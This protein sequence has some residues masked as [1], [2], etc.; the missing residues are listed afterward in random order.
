LLYAPTKPDIYFPLATNPLQLEPTV[1]DVVPYR[2]DPDGEIIPDPG[3]RMQVDAVRKNA[4]AGREL[5]TSLAQQNG[6]LLVDPTEVIVKAV[7]DGENP[8]MVYDSHW[9]SLGHEL[10]AREVARVLQTN[11]CP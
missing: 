2:I 8:F 1:R 7:L 5:I 6:L 4:N 9:N 10:V 11:P 3:V